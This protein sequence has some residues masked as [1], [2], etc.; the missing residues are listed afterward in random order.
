[1]T[2]QRR[3]WLILAAALLILAV[4]AVLLRGRSPGKPRGD[5]TPNTVWT[6]YWDF[7]AQEAGPWDLVLFSCYFNEDGSIYIPPALEKRAPVEGVPGQRIYLSFTNDLQHPD[8]TATQKSPELLKRLFQSEERMGAALDEMTALARQWGCQGVEVDFEK[9]DAELWEGMERFLA[10]AW[11]RTQALGLSLRIVL[12]C[13]A[14]V[15]KLSL[16]QD[17]IY[18]IMCYNLYGLHSGPG[19]KADEAF[20]TRVAQRFS[21]LP[22]IHFA[23]ANGG[24]VWDENGKAVRSLTSEDAWAQAQGQGQTPRRDQASGALHYKYKTDEGAFTVWYGD[25]QTMAYWQEVLSTALGRE[26]TVDLW[27]LE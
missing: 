4:A 17:A 27:R 26:A 13:T 19:A 20:L 7:G 14:P 18:S 1:M 11:Q 9:L 25:E 8:G 23:L 10:Q 22:N 3:I 24:F 5:F 15:E 2:K 21:N 16:P 6:V 12:P